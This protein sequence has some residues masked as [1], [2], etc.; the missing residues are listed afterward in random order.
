MNQIYRLLH[1]SL[2]V[3]ALCLGATV[4]S[5]ADT[6]VLQTEFLVPGTTSDTT[7]SVGSNV[8]QPDSFRV[9]QG[10]VVIPG[11]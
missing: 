1:K 7:Y 9:A 10:S 5:K 2:M 11:V 8:G 4:A 6:V 3:I